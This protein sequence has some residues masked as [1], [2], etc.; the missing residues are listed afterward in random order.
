MANK[1][2][3]PLDR[4]Y[5]K[6][7]IVSLKQLLSYD[8]T[9]RVPD[10]QRGYAW[11]SE[12]LVMWQDIIRLHRTSNRK[13]YTGMLALEEITDERIKADE[14][15]P[16]TTSFYVVDGQQRITSLVIIISSLLSYIN[17]ELPNQDI[18][19]FTDLLSVN[20][21]YRFGYS[22][23]RQDGATE[24]FE[25]RI[26]DNNTGLPH[27][28]RYLSNIDS[29]K[30]FVDKEL[31]KMSGK[32]A[33]ALLATILDRIVFNI[34]FVD[35]FDVRIAFETINNRG[36]RLSKLELLKNRLMYLSTFFPQKDARGNQLKN[37]INIAWKEI[38]NRL[39]FGDDQLSD[40]DYLRAHW[41]VY[42]RLDKRK[43]DAY[44]DDLLNNEF[45]VDSG[46]FFDYASKGE[47]TKAYE[48]IDSYITSLSKYSLYWA[49]VNKP[50]DIPIS[51]AP[52]ELKWIKRLSRISSA[53]YLRAALMVVVSENSLVWADK[54]N[55]YSKVE[56]FV[57]TNKLLAQDKN[58]L[59]FLITSAKDLL[60]SEQSQK[61]QVFKKN[62]GEI[63]KHELKVDADRVVTAIDA[64]KIN[65]LDKKNNYYYDWNGLRYFL[66]EYNE[67]LTVA[68]AAPIEWY[69]LSNT[70]IEH[71]LPQT[72]SKEYWKTAFQ[73][74]DDQ[75]R[76]ITN[77]LGNLLLLSC[78][79]ENST[80]N[81]YIFPVKRTMSVESKKF[82]YSD[83]SRSARQIAKKECWTINEISE[84]TDELIKFMFNHWF[85][86]VPGMN[87][88]KWQRCAMILRNN[89]PQIL[90]E[91][92]YSELKTRL[93]TI[94]TSDERASAN[95]DV[96]VKKPND[97]LHQQF[98]GYIDTD[99][100]PIRY[101][102]KKISYLD[103]YYTFKIISD[104]GEPG[105]FECGV[106]IDGVSYRVRYSY[107]KNE[108]DI[109]YWEN[110]VEKYVMQIDFL[111][112][113]IQPLIVSLFRY[114]RKAY[115]KPEPTW[116]DR[117][118]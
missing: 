64:F 11:D 37:K 49:F 62:I 106:I 116:C 44:I 63:D 43:R 59:S 16:G 61:A 15:V 105:R 111:P 51:I 80:L 1:V 22:I 19:A 104:N 10:Y 26:Y 108:I 55:F 112:K 33:L 115:G 7:D 8:Y 72:P 114:L 77:S 38:Y 21:V 90:D 12:F 71:V 75:M 41:I 109:N 29:A 2:K 102:N 110:S 25:G 85:S 73:Y 69:K 27:A 6:T 30:S 54:E 67:S 50:D 40:D 96:K 60:L 107:E 58:D 82:A 113:K 9:Y 46:T 93:S 57:F 32:D 36:K 92:A 81:N 17:D 47:F 28:D 89:L 52:D 101:N 76:I 56:Q 34:Y 79:A 97:Y 35:D 23:K 88:E 14:A 68:N 45:S 91:S 74:D 95:N 39:C 20:Y 65:V 53:L 42:K 48:L 31:N 94:D 86:N 103:N 78:G 4:K 24:F 66:Y 13:H 87:Q 100:I 84:R 83:G 117:S 3:N 70:S 5:R 118:K 99:T 98:L 18:S